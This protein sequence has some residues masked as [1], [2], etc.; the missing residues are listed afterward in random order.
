MHNKIHILWQLIEWKTFLSKNDQG[1]FWS[2]DLVLE[3][4]HEALIG[5]RK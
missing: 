3:T 1:K 2:R 5:G 4:H